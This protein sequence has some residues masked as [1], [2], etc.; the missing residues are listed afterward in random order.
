MEGK[1]REY[2]DEGINCGDEVEFTPPEPGQEETDAP[3][4]P[5]AVERE[6]DGERL[7]PITCGARRRWITAVTSANTMA[8]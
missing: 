5:E 2:R 3:E 7:N 4:E 1:Q 8:T 6:E